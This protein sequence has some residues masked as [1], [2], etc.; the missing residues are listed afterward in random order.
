MRSAATEA[1]TP[2]SP[3]ADCHPFSALHALERELALGSAGMAR[4]PVV[5][6]KSGMKRMN[7]ES[8]GWRPRSTPAGAVRKSI[9]EAQKALCP[10]GT[11]LFLWSLHNADGYAAPGALEDAL[12]EAVTCV[13]E[14]LL[15]HIGLCNAT[16]LLVERALSV[17]PLLCVQ[18]EWS[19]F[20]REAE[21]QR[22]PTA[23]ASSKKGMLRICA[24][25][26]IFF[27]AHSPL[28]GLKAR[29]G[30]RSVATKQPVLGGLAGK[31]GASPQ[32]VCLAA[33]LGRAAQLGARVLLIP[34]ARTA[35]HTADSCS[36]AALRLSDAE[37]AA[38]MGPVL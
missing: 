21:Q 24:Q 16:G 8:S 18:N 13:K 3:F 37:I 30:E 29:R 4:A 34:G 2:L 31:H 27:V 26:D 19:L 9:E 12:A 1:R 14:G 5:S 35:A 10:T 11:P 25:R 15:L 17:T 20:C 23:A 6:T 33:M 28:G 22:P 32:A 36:A 38:V 7:D